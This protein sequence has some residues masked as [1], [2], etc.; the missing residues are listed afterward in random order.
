MPLPFPYP[1]PQPASETPA[2]VRVYSRADVLWNRPVFKAPPLKVEIPV[3]DISELA[4]G[5]RKPDA[6]ARAAT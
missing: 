3:A 2:I 5:I 1:A 4:F 6:I